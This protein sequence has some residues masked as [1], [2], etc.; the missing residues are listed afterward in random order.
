MSASFFGLLP[1]VTNMIRVDHTHVVSTFH[2]YKSA[3]PARVRKGLV[4]TI[5]TALE[6]HA[7][8]EEEIF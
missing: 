6:I 4:L 8:L 3:A 5:C 7:Q 1:T 2:Q